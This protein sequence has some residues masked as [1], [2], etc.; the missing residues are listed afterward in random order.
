PE[1]E[2][3]TISAPSQVSFSVP[4]SVTACIFYDFSPESQ[5]DL[6]YILTLPNGNT[7]TGS[8]GSS[9]RLEESGTYSLLGTSSDPNSTRCPRTRTF[10]VTINEQLE[11]DYSKR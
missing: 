8:S 6:E 1:T 10:N 3:L 2:T 9:F 11:F 7:L 5:E 4:S